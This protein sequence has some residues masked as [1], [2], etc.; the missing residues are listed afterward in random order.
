MINDSNED[1]FEFHILKQQQI[2]SIYEIVCK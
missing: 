2:L 1:P